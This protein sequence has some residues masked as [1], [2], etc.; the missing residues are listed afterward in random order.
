MTK[1]ILAMFLAVLMVVSIMSTSVL[2]EETPTEEEQKDFCLVHE[3]KAEEHT[4]ENCTY[5]LVKEVEATCQSGGYKLL[6]CNVCNTEFL[7]KDATEQGE[8]VWGE[9]HECE[10]R[11]CTLCGALE[12]TARAEHTW[13]FDAEKSDPCGTEDGK[14]YFHC[15]VCGAEKDEP[16]ADGHKWT[17]T[18]S[19]WNEDGS[20][21]EVTGKCAYCDKE[22]TADVMVGCVHETSYTYNVSTIVKVEKVEPTCTTTGMKEYY[23]CTVCGGYFW[24]TIVDP[25][26][27]HPTTI[28]EQ[29]FVVEGEED[30]RVIGKLAHEAFLSHEDLTCVDNGQPLYCKHCGQIC[31]QVNEPHKTGDWVIDTEATCAAPG[32]QHREC[33]LCHEVEYQE[34]AQLE[35]EWDDG[36]TTIKPTCTDDG[37]MTY[38]CRN[39]GTTKTEVIDALGHDWDAPATCM[40]TAECARCHETLEGDHNW[41]HD[42]DNVDEWDVEK[43]ATCVAQG[44]SM[45]I[46]LT[47]GETVFETTD[48]LGHE[49]KH[50]TVPATCIRA[51]YTYDICVRECCTNTDKG[52]QSITIDGVEY[53]LTAFTFMKVHQYNNNK[54]LY[55]TGKV[56]SSK[57]SYW[58]AAS[59][60]VEDAVQVYLEAAYIPKAESADLGFRMYFYT[61]NDPVNGTKTYIT[62]TKSGYYFNAKLTTEAP[63]ELWNLTLMTTAYGDEWLYTMD[64]DGTKA[65]LG[66]Y[67]SG[68]N[69]NVIK[70]SN[71][72]YLKSSK[73]S[74][75][76]NLVPDGLTD[77]GGVYLLG[78]VTILDDGAFN[79]NNHIAYKESISEAG[80][81]TEGRYAICCAECNVTIWETPIGAMGHEFDKWTYPETEE[82]TFY[83]PTCTTTGWGRHFCSRCDAWE[84]AVVPALGH[85]WNQTGKTN[86]TCT[87]WGSITWECDCDDCDATYTLNKTL[88]VGETE[89][90]SAAKEAEVLAS[91]PAALKITQ[92]TIDG[93]KP[94]GHVNP[95]K[96]VVVHE[97]TCTSQGEIRY[98]C[99]REGCDYSYTEVLDMT[100]HNWV[101]VSV[102]KGNH[103]NHNVST[104]QKCADCE[105][106]RTLN[107][108]IDE[109]GEQITHW[110]YCKYQFDSL[111]EAAKIHGVSVDDLRFDSWVIA[112]NCYQN[113]LA[114]YYCNCGDSLTD[115][116]E[117]AVYVKFFEDEYGK[118]GEHIWAT[119]A[120]GGYYRSD[121]YYGATANVTIEYG[122]AS[123]ISGTTVI[124]KV[125]DSEGNELI[126]G[127]DVTL[128]LYSCD[129]NDYD[130]YDD[131]ADYYDEA[132]ALLTLDA[133]YLYEVLAFDMDGEY[134]NEDLTLVVYTEIDAEDANTD[135]I[136][137]PGI[138]I[139]E[140]N[141]IVEATCQ[142]GS[143]EY[144]VGCTRPGCDCYNS[145][146][147]KWYK[148]GNEVDCVF[149]PHEFNCPGYVKRGDTSNYYYESC[150]WC[151]EK[152]YHDQYIIDE[153]TGNLCTDYVYKIFSCY[154]GEAHALYFYGN[155]GHQEYV[156][157]YI[158]PTHTEKGSIVYGCQLCD[159]YERTEEIPTTEH[160]N[161]IGQI[162]DPS[163]AGNDE[164]DI[165]D[166][167]YANRGEENYPSYYECVLCNENVMQHG[168]GTYGQYHEP[169]CEA[170][171]YWDYRCDVCGK[172][173][174][175]VNFNAPAHGHDWVVG[176]VNED[177]SVVSTCHC[178]G[179]TK[180]GYRHI[181]I[182]LN[183]EEYTY[184]SKI[185]V[186]VSLDNLADVSVRQWLFDL[187]YDAKNVTFVGAKTLDERFVVDNT[188][189]ENADGKIKVIGVGAANS[190][191]L[192]EKNALVELYFVVHTNDV[193]ELTFRVENI[194]AQD[195]VAD[196]EGNKVA[197]DVDLGDFDSMAA[198]ADT[199]L[200]GDAN[201]DGK[202]DIYDSMYAFDLYYSR[203]YN[204]AIDMN[205]D[206][207]ITLE[208][209]YEVIDLYLHN[210]TELNIVLSHLSDY[211]AHLL[212]YDVIH[213]SHAECE[214]TYTENDK[215]D[216]CPWCGTQQHLN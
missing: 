41:K 188:D 34:I 197:E 177:G 198:I 199:V 60:N 120:P 104:E 175:K 211:E 89:E 95:L 82:G 24:G 111:E 142:H 35:H 117:A 66:A 210:I 12:E 38:T 116:K 129:P 21:A 205:C 105:Q 192:N 7:H 73:A 215:I 36:I 6:K 17:W 14:R 48:K 57:Y 25:E 106:T 170:Y 56:H 183:G 30:P 140:E 119:A 115:D 181:N 150:Q 148:T 100:E 166:A 59:E 133:K 33:E 208:D 171:G 31:G 70:G 5:T 180:T 102:N 40:H 86:P 127:K 58:L 213:C 47:C 172:D 92:E 174:I 155:V 109:N 67:G 84:D 76:M 173:T 158:A 37:L 151:G 62:M 2:A 161:S 15:S 45:N 74:T 214:F 26:G 22:I 28:Y 54:D 206:G 79:P 83:A 147:G 152:H 44:I 178:C 207:E 143:Y 154:C 186:T 193:N 136:V 110:V 1:K 46:C 200:L 179:A 29:F 138:V 141:K 176:E 135:S 185:T 182:A 144:I 53:D 63:D 50:I 68:D 125:Y 189:P 16:T 146:A 23:T 163:C 131:T 87:G 216:Y 3:G 162:I 42:M 77:N 202:V 75:H 19:K 64:F 97:A 153:H 96:W 108:Y 190:Q 80:C 134:F 99:D 139:T 20:V 55:F 167:F 132:G 164:K 18:P 130:Y 160:V 72:S 93:I 81:T 121:A 88:L 122:Y 112:G 71:V 8:H 203:E 194:D 128:E 27:E 145:D 114:K 201:R 69:A 169:T 52:Q 184:G 4:T 11:T 209:V 9:A 126:I 90:E 103:T 149:V 156:K 159:E 195:M 85:D 165:Y 101:D 32:S 10:R 39:C 187:T 91:A 157:E 43:A 168:S 113:G 49:V 94:L 204:V 13:V 78:N 118:F 65:Y 191:K 137:V 123:G 196:S 124:F 51:G 212:G 98:Y 61:D 107:Y